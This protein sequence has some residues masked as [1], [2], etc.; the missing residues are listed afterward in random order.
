MGVR[1]WI[2]KLQGR[3]QADVDLARVVYGNMAAGEAQRS[4][5]EVAFRQDMGVNHVLISDDGVEKLFDTLMYTNDEQGKVTG[6]NYDMAALR[7]LA[8]HL[9]A[10]SFINSEH[11]R[12]LANLYADSDLQ[13]I[14]MGMNE[15]EYNSEINS[16][17]DAFALFVR[18]RLGNADQGKL[19]RLLKMQTR[20]LQM[21][22]QEPLGKA[23][24]Q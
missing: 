16:L 5:T 15:E 6:V 12:R 8:S 14:R 10:T 1:D 3:S 24:A 2:K 21:Q 20:T 18:V 13:R 4:D 23:K 9:L 7:V 19:A 11:D 22:M 17:L